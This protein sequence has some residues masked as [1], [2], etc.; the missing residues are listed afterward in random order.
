MMALLRRTADPGNGEGAQWA[1]MRVHLVPN[2]I[3]DTLGYSS[4]MNAEWDFLTML[5][6]EG[7]EVADEFLTEHGDS[8]GK[9]STLDIDRIVEGV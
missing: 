2:K 4:K 6:D 9:R 5:R 1:R 3:M 7:R 8:I